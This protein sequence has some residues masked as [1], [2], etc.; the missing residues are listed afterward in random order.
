MSLQCHLRKENSP[1]IYSNITI[2]VKFWV[3]KPLPKEGVITTTNTTPT[4]D[5]AVQ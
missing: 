5:K 4:T 2:V 3:G 1:L